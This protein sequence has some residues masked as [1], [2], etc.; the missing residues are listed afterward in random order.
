MHRSA[1]VLRVWLM[2]GVQSSRIEVPLLLLTLPLTDSQVF[3]ANLSCK[4]AL[5]ATIAE[6]HKFMSPEQVCFNF[7]SDCI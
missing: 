6:L 5:P 2:L 3:C 4:P 7:R 1:H